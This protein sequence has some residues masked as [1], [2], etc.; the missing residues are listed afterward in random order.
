MLK[1]IRLLMMLCF[2]S[3]VSVLSHAQGTC[4]NF[5]AGVCPSAPYAPATG[6]TNFYFISTS[7]SDA[8]SGASEASPWAHL[9][10]MLTFTGSHTPVAGD[11]YILRGCDDWGNAN[12]PITWTHSG[13]SSNYIYIGVDPGWNSTCATPPAWTLSTGYYLSSVIKPTSGN[14]GGYTFS[15]VTTDLGTCTSGTTQPGSWNQTV[16]GT[17]TDTAGGG[18]C[19][20]YNAG[21]LTWNRPIFDAGAAVIHPPECTNLNAFWTS[22]SSSFV[23]VNWIELTGYF[24]ASANSGGSCSGNTF[25]VGVSTSASN[26]QWNNSYIHNWTHG[27]S[28]GDMN[29]NAFS[30]GC[31]TCLMD[32]T[33]VDNFDGSHYSGGGQQWPTTHSIFAYATNAIK[34][35]MSGEYGY[36]NISHLG[37]NVGGNHPNCIETIGGIVGSGNFYIHDNWIHGMPN[38]PTEQCET[39]Q[40]GNTGETDYVFN[41]VWCCHIGGGDVAQ[42]PQNNQPNVNGLYFIN[43]V[44]EEDLGN[45]VC[46][47]ASNATSWLN[48]FVMVNNFCLVP[49][50]PNGTTQ[51]QKLMSGSTITSPSTLVFSNNIV[52]Q[53]S[54][55]NGHGCIATSTFPYMPSVGCQD[56][57]GI[58][59]NLTATYWPGGFST[60]D[61]TLAC[62]EQTVNGVVQ[63]VCPRRT[64]N[65]RPSSG[66]WDSGPYEFLNAKPNPP[67]LFYM[68]GAE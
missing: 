18:T 7:G 20:W 46:A 38:S 34:P 14:A 64:S 66:A 12:F 5:N 31:A 11:G 48:A 40:V 58:G 36:N 44:W 29:G 10:Q 17:T 47:N 15:P 49:N 27:G 21:L 24:W 45:G 23:V 55:A 28:S 26:V 37:N 60:N 68:W 56:T 42:F 61:T 39:L 2:I 54:V 41:N 32:H 52:E 51:S 59:S 57:V 50:A 33:V 35:H 62:L 4:S 8:N 63:S 19:T 1:A 65:S 43:N 30:T 16:G 25:W 53:I 9:P 6:V 3:V 22:G 13:T 67:V